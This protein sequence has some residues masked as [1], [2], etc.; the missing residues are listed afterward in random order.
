MNVKRFHTLVAVVVTLL[1]AI[2]VRCLSAP[3]YGGYVAGGGDALYRELASYVMNPWL[4]SGLLLG[5]MVFIVIGS[6]MPKGHAGLIGTIPILLVIASSSVLGVVTPLG[7]VLMLSGAGLVLM[8]AHVLPGRG[9]YAGGGVICIFLGCLYV[10]GSP[11][12]EGPVTTIS[13][14]LVA[15]M[16][17]ASMLVYI[18]RSPKWRSLYNE[19]S[20]A[21]CHPHVEAHAGVVSRVQ[22]TGQ[23][24]Q[25]RKTAPAASASGAAGESLDRAKRAV[26]GAVDKELTSLEDPAAIGS[27]II[28]GILAKLTE[29]R[30][31]SVPV[32]AEETRLAR[33]RDSAEARLTELD[34]GAK[35]AVL[36]GRDDLAE[37]LLSRRDC[38]R[39]TIEDLR[40]QFTAAKSQADRVRARIEAMQDDL[41][42]AGK[43]VLDASSKKE[44]AGL[45]NQTQDLVQQGLNPLREIED[46]LSQSASEIEAACDPSHEA[47][48]VDHQARYAARAKR[49]QDALANL[50]SEL[51]ANGRQDPG[52]QYTSEE[53]TDQDQQTIRRSD[54]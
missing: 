35:Q 21:L 36:A 7:L 3:P 10:Q 32:L 27:Q 31:A 16:S 18:P 11:L 40:D 9:I 19:A 44:L 37:D 38:Y 48:S 41:A 47:K 6:L 53:T 29:L 22:V 30:E 50:K 34:S 1:A 28:E 45:V 2:S 23:A 14:A 51:G 24:G 39:G 43:R 54:Q 5:G 46:R 20:S 15:L 4:S 13:S 52:K 49:A 12:A 26:I 33:L 17:M 42:A 25:A 8:E